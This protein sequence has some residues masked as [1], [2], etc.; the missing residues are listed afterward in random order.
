[1]MPS[2]RA[3]E[4]RTFPNGRLRVIEWAGVRSA[5]REGAPVLKPVE[6][7]RLVPLVRAA[8]AHFELGLLVERSTVAAA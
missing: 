7:P 5:G 8:G 3:C 6:A 2:D 1:M 4:G